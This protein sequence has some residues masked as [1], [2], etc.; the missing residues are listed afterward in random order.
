VYSFER[1][2]SSNIAR[3]IKLSIRIT[4]L[5][6]GYIKNNINIITGYWIVGD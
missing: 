1:Y 4:I 3:P 2:N 5:K 6:K